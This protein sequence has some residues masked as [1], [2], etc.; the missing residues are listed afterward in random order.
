MLAAW[1]SVADD[2]RDARKS[3]SQI[4]LNCIDQSVR[5]ADRKGGIDLAM[6]INDLSIRRLANAN[7]VRLANTGDF[8]GKRTQRFTNFI[9]ACRVRITSGKHDCGQRLDMGLD[10]HVRAKLF[11][12]RLFKLAGDLVGCGERQCTVDFKIGRDRQ[13]LGK[14]LHGDVMDRQ[15]AVAR[16]QHHPFTHRFVVERSRLGDDG[17]LGFGEFGADL[18]R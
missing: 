12:D 15:P 10:L 3:P 14:R 8:G 7:V 11:A 9:D 5:G 16:N 17:H 6:E 13:M 18:A 1:F 2:A 4:P